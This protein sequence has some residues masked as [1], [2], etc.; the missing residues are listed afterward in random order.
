MSVGIGIITVRV[1]SLANLVGTASGNRLTQIGGPSQLT[2]DGV[3]LVPGNKV[4]LTAQTDK[5]ENGLWIVNSDGTATAWELRRQSPLSILKVGQLYFAKEGDTCRCT[6]CLQDSSDDPIQVGSS[7]LTFEKVSFECGCQEDCTEP[8]G[9]S[10]RCFT[11]NLTSGQSI[12]DILDALDD[13]C[14]FKVTINLESGQPGGDFTYVHPTWKKKTDC[15]LTI[16]GDTRKVCGLG[17]THGAKMDGLGGN[18]IFEEFDNTAQGY[19]NTMNIAISGANT[20]LTCVYQNPAVTAPGDTP[21]GI[22]Q[23]NFDELVEDDEVIWFDEDGNTEVLSVMSGANNVVTLKEVIPVDLRPGEGAKGYG[24]IVCPGNRFQGTTGAL[25]GFRRVCLKGLVIKCLGTEFFT[26]GNP[27]TYIQNCS[28]IGGDN[29]TF[30]AGVKNVQNMFLHQHNGWAHCVLVNPA[31]CF[32][33]GVFQTMVGR[34]GHFMFESNPY[35]AVV[36]SV[37]S[38]LDG[39]GGDRITDTRSTGPCGLYGANGGQLCIA[40]S[41]VFNCPSAGLRMT[42][43]ETNVQFTQW[44]NNGNNPSARTNGVDATKAL[45]FSENGAIIMDYQSK[46]YSEPLPGLPDLKPTFVTN[47]Y[48]V[49]ARTMSKAHIPG[50]VGVGNATNKLAHDGVDF[51]N[52]GAGD[53]EDDVLGTRSSVIKYLSELV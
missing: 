47:D 48:A 15:Q 52:I 18:L 23:P 34:D 1:A 44:C 21:S 28:L 14:C 51:V 2:I 38:G 8:C 53:A 11:Y 36:F 16:C 33:R 20:I 3:D 43:A 32:I 9:C 30:S 42:C 35:S 26:Y 17:I 39:P 27:Q 40:A 19:G 13:K 37:Y 12:Q 49:W 24:F 25:V 29:D 10:A 7:D 4:L 41:D 22:V 45:A 31:G 5:S 50:A 46:V 6:W